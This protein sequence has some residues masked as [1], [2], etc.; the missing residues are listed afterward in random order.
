VKE[1]VAWMKANRARLAHP[2][3]G[4]SGHMGVTLLQRAIG[5]PADFIPYRGGGPA[6]QDVMAGHV[7]ITSVTIGNGVDPIANGVVKGVVV[8]SRKRHRLLPDV[9]S[10]F[11][12]IEPLSEALFWNVLLA[13]AGT[14]KE[15]VDKIAAAF[16]ETIKDKLL[17][18][19]WTRTGV[20]VYPPEQRTPEGAREYLRGEF[21]RWEKTI[22]EYKVEGLA[23]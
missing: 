18:D 20:D 5:A 22:R 19:S 17:V 6:L 12:E 3:V 23:Q 10:I 8:L 14:P 16:E 4:S 21:A 15:I 13:P 9:P 11:E 7:D 1:L 2:G